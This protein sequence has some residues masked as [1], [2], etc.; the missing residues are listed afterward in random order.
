ML[1]ISVGIHAYSS[2]MGILYENVL[3]WL[4]FVTYDPSLIGWAYQSTILYQPANAQINTSHLI[5]EQ[6]MFAKNLFK[7]NDSTFKLL[8]YGDYVSSRGVYFLFKE[9]FQ[10]GSSDT[11]CKTIT[12]EATEVSQFLSHTSSQCFMFV[13]ILCTLLRIYSSWKLIK[14]SIFIKE[15]Q[16]LLN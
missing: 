14:F 1:F 13:S 16:Q 6:L 11:M 4:N 7:L 2:V 10:T 9:D 5:R 12:K 15:A 3:S 8:L